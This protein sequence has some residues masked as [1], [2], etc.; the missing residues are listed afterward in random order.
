[1]LYTPPLNS[2]V[3]ISQHDTRCKFSLQ[4]PLSNIPTQSSPKSLTKPFQS[5]LLSSHRLSLKLRKWRNPHESVNAHP[6]VYQN[7]NIKCNSSAPFP[8]LLSAVE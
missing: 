7:E 3:H 5:D 1:M 8:E 6:L 2:F 4:I